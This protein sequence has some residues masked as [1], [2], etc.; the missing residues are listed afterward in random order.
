[1]QNAAIGDPSCIDF[2]AS[3]LLA[4]SPKSGFIPFPTKPRQALLAGEQFLHGALFDVALFGEELL[5][6]FDE[7]IRIAQRL[8]DR[9]L[10][11]FGG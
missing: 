4:T 5:Q 10:F 7:G 3:A 2:L 6:R 8:G 11:G 1:M 9:F